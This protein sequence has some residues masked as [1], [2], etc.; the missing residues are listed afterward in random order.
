MTPEEL[1]ARLPPSLRRI[2]DRMAARWPGRVA[3]G[4]AGSLARIEIF[5][6]AMTVAAQIFTSVFPL[7]IMAATWLDTSRADE[8]AESIQV[9]EPTRDVL[10]P[11]IDATG[12]SSAFG[13]V[14][15]IVVLISATSLSR[16]ITRA[17][18]AIWGIERPKTN[19]GDAWRWLAAVVTLAVSVVVS[20]YIVVAS[21]GLPPPSF[22][23][24]L[25]SSA[26]FGTIAAFV[27]WLLLAGR[28]PSRSLAPGA[29][30]FAGCLLL[31]HPVSSRY[32]DLALRSSAERFGSIGVAF[33]YLAWLYAV[34]FV[35]LGTAALGQVI[36]M[37]ESPLGR[38]IRRRSIA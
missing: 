14:G 12:T 6:R 24:A 16:A 15:T 20:H 27:P 9:P 4:T 29:I 23:S 11:A 30:I 21:A 8:L 32:L 26:V 31:A 36:A 10:Q 18:V 1:I 35:L 13:I 19:V 5:D 7:L 28:V 3:L 17:Y 37:D 33:T 25:A 34:S 22:W 2:V 38:L